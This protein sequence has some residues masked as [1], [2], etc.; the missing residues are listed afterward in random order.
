MWLLTAWPFRPRQQLEEIRQ[1]Q[2]Q[3]ENTAGRKKREVKESLQGES[4][5]EKAQEKSKGKAALTRM[6]YSH[7][8]TWSPKVPCEQ[9]GGGALP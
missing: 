1:K 9:D 5:G 6:A 3:R 2:E 4:A 8:K 7:S